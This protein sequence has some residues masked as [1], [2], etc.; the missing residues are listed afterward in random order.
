LTVKLIDRDTQIMNAIMAYARKT[1]QKNLTQ[2][3]INNSIH[4]TKVAFFILPE[5][6]I[7]MP[8]YNLARLAA[9]TRN[10]GFETSVYDL[11]VEGYKESLNWD[12]G[13]DAWDHSKDWLWGDMEYYNVLHPKLKS[14]FDRYIN[15]IIEQQFDVVGFTLYYCN[16]KPSNYFSSRLKELNPNIITIAGGPQCHHKSGEEFD[17]YDIIIAG[18]AEKA[19]LNVLELIEQGKKPKD[20]IFIK[21]KNG[22][23]LDLDNLPWADYSDID[24]N[25]Y[26]MPNGVNAE[27]SRGCTAKCVFCSET[28]FWKYRS[29][30]A[31]NTLSEILNLNEKYGITYIWFLDSLVNGNIDELKAF[32]KGMIASGKNIKW[33]G[34]A[35][36]D[37]RMDF[38]FYEDLA[39]AG[40]DFLSYGI[41]SGSASVLIGM[42]KRITIDVI[43]RN[44]QDG[45]KV[46]VKAHCNWILG[47]PTETIFNFYESL[48]LIWRNKNAIH[49]ISVGHGFTEPPDTILSQNSEAYGLIKAYYQKNWINNTY[50]NSKFHRML[51][52]IFMNI[53]LQ[54][55]Q[56]W[57]RTLEQQDL[58]QFYTLSYQKINVIDNLEFENFN[59]HIVND[60]QLTSFA[61]SL[62]N[63]IWPLLRILWRTHQNYE[64]KL[65][66]TPE[67][68][69]KWFGDRLAGN[70]TIDYDFKIDANGVGYAIFDFDYKQDE[71]A[72]IY[73]D[74][75]DH[76]SVSAERAR[77]LA[78]HRNPI[79]DAELRREKNLKFL[80]HL[81]KN[82]D[83]SFVYQLKKIIKW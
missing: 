53:F 66:I 3:K 78:L 10:A 11:N 67:W 51:R 71:G 44:L 73:S 7:K 39:A 65:K 19:I 52:I 56:G 28:H 4:K 36:C 61:N 12:L 43:E 15:L 33:T 58:S 40:C 38:D 37:E 46:G 55:A 77:K 68:C 50:T 14:L 70:L 13:F 54:Q 64:F 80:D 23:R 20:K 6:A 1:P 41:E 34:Y 24:F 17:D 42:D 59:M 49:S 30:S 62:I 8:P 74:Y 81:T 82:V 26:L 27:F 29:R 18:E 45:K 48:E 60:T 57:D 72:W 75:S 76:Q 83:F 69:I 5:W 63:E 2:V 22:E 47:F 25:N 21:Q 16:K 9:V 79:E 35:R 31:S 32:C